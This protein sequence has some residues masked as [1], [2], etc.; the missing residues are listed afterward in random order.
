MQT[1]VY[2]MCKNKINIG[3]YDSQEDMQLML[4]VFY[5]GGRIS[6]E[7]YQ[8]LAALLNGRHEQAEQ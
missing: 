5:A 3:F 7:H 1:I 2:T 4:D 6:V 8:E